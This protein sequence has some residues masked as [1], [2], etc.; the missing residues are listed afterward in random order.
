MKVYALT[1]SIYKSEMS[2]I[3]RDF[4][5]NAKAI[6]QPDSIRNFTSI[7]PID[8]QGDSYTIKL[9]FE[10]RYQCGYPLVIARF[11]VN[12]KYLPKDTDPY[13]FVDTGSAFIEYQVASRFDK[14]DFYPSTVMTRDFQEVLDTVN[15][16]DSKFESL[17][18]IATEA[19]QDICSIIKYGEVQ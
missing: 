9:G 13:E 15:F 17:C 11:Y 8:E 12:N 5:S 1:N 10:A 6:V 16:F 3:F 18:E 14:S 2:D 4:L 7:N 19:E